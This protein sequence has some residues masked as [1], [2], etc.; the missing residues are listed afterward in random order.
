MRFKD[1]IFLDYYDPTI[2]I[3][4]KKILP[5]NN[6]N[7]NSKMSTLMV[8]QNTLYSPFLNSHLVKMDIFYHILSKTNS[9]ST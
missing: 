8:K 4:H 5:F 6:E 1:D 3:T 7:L 9:L 2:Q